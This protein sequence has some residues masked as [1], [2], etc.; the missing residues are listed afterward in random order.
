MK[1]YTAQ[2]NACFDCPCKI[3]DDTGDY[4]GHVS[5]LLPSNDKGRRI[6]QVTL[7]SDK[8]PQWCPLPEEPAP[9]LYRGHVTD[10]TERSYGPKQAQFFRGDPDR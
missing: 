9:S 3:T 4:C 1:L 6:R 10:D 8:A 2:V 5:Q 7:D